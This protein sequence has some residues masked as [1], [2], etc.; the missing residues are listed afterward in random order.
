MNSSYY[1]YDDDYLM[2]E[3]SLPVYSA[4]NENP[5]DYLIEIYH[6]IKLMQSDITQ[7][8][9]DVNLIRHDTIYTSQIN[10]DMNKIRNYLDLLNYRI[11]SGFSTV[12][13]DIERL[14]Y[15]IN[16]SLVNHSSHNGSERIP[17]PASYSLNSGKTAYHFHK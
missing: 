7:L 15:L 6:D 17:T 4:F 12:N 11:V 3:Y 14:I 1:Y 8:K 2:K 13:Y 9:H 5:L 10:Y 16:N